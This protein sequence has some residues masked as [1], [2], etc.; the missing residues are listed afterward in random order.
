MVNF[1][2][3]K[4]QGLYRKSQ[5]PYLTIVCQRNY[6]DTSDQLLTELMA[7]K[8]GLIYPDRR[9]QLSGYFF[10]LSGENLLYSHHGEGIGEY[11]QLLVECYQLQWFRQL[12]LRQMLFEFQKV[13]VDVARGNFNGF[14]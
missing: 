8:L 5:Q 13:F 2:G 10:Q 1:R 14:S 7:L 4:V 11:A 12:V 6:L 9:S 3:P